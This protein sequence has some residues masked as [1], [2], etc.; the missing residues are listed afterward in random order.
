MNSQNELVFNGAKHWHY[1]RVFYFHTFQDS[2]QLLCDLVATSNRLQ[3]MAMST[4]SAEYVE[5]RENVPDAWIVDATSLASW[6]E[7]RDFDTISRMVPVIVAIKNVPKP[8]DWVR[9]LSVDNWIC[10][11]LSLT[12]AQL[13]ESIFDV[14]SASSRVTPS[15]VHSPTVHVADVTVLSLTRED[16]VNTRILN[17]ISHGLSDKDI[18]SSMCLSAHTVR[19]RISRMLQDSGVENRTSLAL[20]FSQ[21]NRERTR[22]HLRHERSLAFP[23]AS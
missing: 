10:L 22:Q 1:L 19:N 7:R 20:L 8:D 3:V 4:E 6:R 5:L 17:L 16:K 11:D 23:Y 9:T 13:A 14:V 12:D 21:S 18:A 2:S 15:T